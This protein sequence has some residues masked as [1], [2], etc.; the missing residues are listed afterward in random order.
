MIMMKTAGFEPTYVCE[1]LECSQ[2]Q[3]DFPP[4][5]ECLLKKGPLNWVYGFKRFRKWIDPDE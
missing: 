2:T 3:Y 4:N 5:T 1:I